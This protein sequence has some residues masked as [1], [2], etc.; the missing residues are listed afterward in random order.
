MKQTFII[1]IPCNAVSDGRAV[2][3]AIEN[4]TFNNK[5][6]LLNRL[7]YDEDNPI[8]AER[9]SILPLTEYMDL[10]NDQDDDTPEEEKLDLLDVW[11]GYV[12][13]KEQVKTPEEPKQ[14]KPFRVNAKVTTVCYI[15]VMAHDEAHAMEL[16]EDIDGGDFI[17]DDK[18]TGYFSIYQAYE[19][20][21]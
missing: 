20:K 10:C 14:L 17:T 4:D 7:C 8:D 5:E 13:I 9:V 21:N 2:L 18:D 15:D 12:H 16:A 3:E 1:L 11:T 19:Q 6:A